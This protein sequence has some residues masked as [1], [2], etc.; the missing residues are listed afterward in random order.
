MIKRTVPPPILPP[1]DS[2]SLANFCHLVQY[3]ENGFP[4]FKVVLGGVVIV[5]SEVDHVDVARSRPVEV[6]N[7]SVE[8]G[9]QPVARRQL[10]VSGKALRGKNSFS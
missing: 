8:P 5:H 2:R 6:G 9:R 7:D 4:K 1:Y 3:R 10:R